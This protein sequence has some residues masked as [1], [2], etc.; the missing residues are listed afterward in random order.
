M[1]IKFNRFEWAGSFGDV[2]TDLPLLLAMVTAAQLDVGSTF[3]MFGAMQILTGLVY[4]LPMPMQPLKAMAV[5]VIAQKV[6]SSTLFMAGILIGVVM[7]LFTLTGL[8]E[9]LKNLVPHH[10]VRGIQLGLAFSLIKIALLNY[11]FTAELPG[12]FLALFAGIFFAIARLKTKLPAAFIFI[13]AGSL[14]A[15][16]LK[17]GNLEFLLSPQLSL[18][19]L[20]E[21][22]LTELWPAFV[23]LVLPQFP[24]SLANSV[25]ATQQTVADLFPEKKVSLKKIGLSY[26][27]ANLIS[28]IFSGIP[29]CHG[30]GGLAGHYGFGARTGGSVIIY[31]TFY[32]LTGLFFAHALA[33]ITAFFPPPL[34]G[35]ILFFEALVIM[36]L[37]SDL[38]DQRQKLGIALMVGAVCV[39]VPQGFLVGMIF[40]V[41]LSWIMDNESKHKDLI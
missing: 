21:L 16:G 38:K 5:L 31:G 33:K 29:V 17:G 6:S 24:L 41:G 15:L 12:L 34:L 19:V 37:A 4:G 28:P 18:P 32:L 30:S 9:K 35:V 27:I 10:V 20:A 13:F 23:V 3:I 8:L 14:Y 1:S 26:G 36:R 22:K 40:G 7:L 39:L 11:I 25:L 2:G